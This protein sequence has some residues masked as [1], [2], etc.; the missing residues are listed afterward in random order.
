MRT[1][2][3]VGSCLLAS[4]ACSASLSSADRFGAGEATGPDAGFAPPSEQ[5]PEGGVGRIE[6]NGIVLVHAASFPAFRVC[7]VGLAAER[8]IPNDDVMPESN[9]A[10]VEIGTAVRLAPRK[11]PLGEAFVFEERALRSTPL[12]DASCSD[13]L[14]GTFRSNAIAVGEVTADVSRGVH[15]LVLAGCRGALAD[16]YASVER[17]GP[18]WN[19]TSGNLALTTLPLPAYAAPG[20]G[21][22]GVQ[23]VQLSQGIAHRAGDRALGVAFGPLD[24]AGAPFV[25]GPLPFGAPLP[26][27]PATL[28]IPNELTDFDTTGVEV[29]VARS[30]DGGVADSGDP[31]REILFRQSLADIQRRSAPRALPPD[32][33][34]APSS[35]VVLALGEHDPRDP[36]GGGPDDDERRALHLVALP[37]AEPDAGR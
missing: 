16:P 24:D 23:I 18:T 14:S 31:D 7:F 28:E 1:F 19:P 15:L 33:Y 35:Y 32:W 8:A 37:L 4:V 36:D 13:L 6:A 10:G 22:L 17:C 30:G 3:L 2:V 12:R 21:R 11:E 34:R 29:S 26:S 27:V 9:V 25:E 20:E 5:D